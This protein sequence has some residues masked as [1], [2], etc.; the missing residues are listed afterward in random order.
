M[1][2]SVTFNAFGNATPLYAT[3][4]GLSKEDLPTESC[5][6][7]ILTISLPGFC[8][9]GCQDVSNSSI[10][11]LVFI[12]STRKKDDIS[13]NQLNHE[14]YRNNVFLPYVQA[15]SKHYLKR[16]GWDIG[17]EVEDDHVWIGW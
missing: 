6:S 1:R 7:G 8:Y 16:E 12:R 9:G 5:P 15:T 13:T 10:G 3:I 2:H 17:D 14:N 4:Y 11:Y